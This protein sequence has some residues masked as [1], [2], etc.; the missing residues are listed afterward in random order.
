MM[1]SSESGL[2]GGVTTCS[3]GQE[4][5]RTALSQLAQ[6]TS[7]CGAQ[8]SSG[9]LR[10]GDT[11]MSRPAEDAAP[12]S[13]SSDIPLRHCLHT[14]P[15]LLLTASALGLL[16]SCTSPSPPPPWVEAEFQQFLQ[17]PSGPL[18]LLLSPPFLLAPLAE[19]VTQRLVTVGLL[20]SHLDVVASACRS[21]MCSGQP[22]C[23]PQQATHCEETGTPQ[24][25]LGS[26]LVA[27]ALHAT[28]CASTG[29]L[30]PH[31]KDFPALHV[32]HAKSYGR[33]QNE[34]QELY[35]AVL[36]RGSGRRKMCTY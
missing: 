21:A 34:A 22:G 29:S 32:I 18:Q 36:A 10:M 20:D 33:R 3:W 30:H 27:S 28:I 35:E 1:V 24:Q 15:Y 2:Q 8:L 19:G 11:G 12:S 31:I 23:F 25:G 14:L 16:P 7:A 17:D 26:H 5:L 9:L 6:T 4:L 13:D